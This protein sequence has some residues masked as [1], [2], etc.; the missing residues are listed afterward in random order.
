MA[1]YM[2]VSLAAHTH[3]VQLPF[4]LLKVA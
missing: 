4:T 3:C 1:P 2:G